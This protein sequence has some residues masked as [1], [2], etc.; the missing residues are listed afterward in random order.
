MMSAGSLALRMGIHVC[1]LKSTETDELRVRRKDRELPGPCRD[2]RKKERD[3]KG[4]RPSLS[5]TPSVG[6][7]ESEPV[8]QEPAT[9]R[10]RYGGRKREME[11][12]NLERLQARYFLLCLPRG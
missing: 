2:P 4:T 7:N 3:K 10:S 6:G 11:R 9:E 12:I 1:E 5:A 8:L